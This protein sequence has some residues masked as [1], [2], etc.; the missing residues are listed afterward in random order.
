MDD[1]QSLPD[2]RDEHANLLEKPM[3]D[4]HPYAIVGIEVEGLFGYIDQKLRT[5]K[6]NRDLISRLAILYGENGTG[7]TTLLRLAFHLLSPRVDRGH[8][9]RL[10]LTPFKSL[11][12]ASYF[13]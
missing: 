1:S 2:P 9:T 10:A 4:L 7:K 6:E 11:S 8:K 13:S 5:T 3:S 12:I